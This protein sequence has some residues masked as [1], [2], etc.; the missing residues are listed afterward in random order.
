[1]VGTIDAV[2]SENVSES[3][4]IVNR[5]FKLGILRCAAAVVSC[6]L[7][8]S[9]FCVSALTAVSAQNTSEKASA[10]GS[11]ESAY[12]LGPDDEITVRALDV[13]EIDGKNARIDRSGSVDLPLVGKLKAAGLSVSQFETELTKR[14]GKYVR[15]P[16]VSV[17]VSEYKSQPVSV[18]GA[19]NTP[20]IYNITGPTT[21]EQVLSRAGGLRND[22]GNTINITRSQ[23]WGPI[24]LSSMKVDATGGFGT[25]NVSAKSLMDAS[26]PRDNII[27]EPTDVISVPRADLVYVVGAVNKS[28]GFVLNERASMSVLQAVSLAEGLEKTAAPKNAKIVRNGLT[29]K[30]QEIPVNLSKILSGN[31]PDMPL[32]ANDILFVP[33]SNA[34]SA[35][36]RVLEAAIQTGTGIAIFH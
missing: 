11:L 27:V 34:K 1:M 8:V 15:E 7:V 19:V 31:S 14:L 22:A 24:P 13:D 30:K 16:Q 29:D 28:G 23:A 9:C 21:L 5:C 32:L 17:T 2:A 18:L 12:L 4:V 33:N 25:A 3:E 35:T 20:G 6:F 26:D 36:Y 10:S